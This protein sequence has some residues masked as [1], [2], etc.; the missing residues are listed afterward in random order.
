MRGI[1]H[2]M[3]HFV[4]INSF[5]GGFFVRMLSGLG[6]LPGGTGL[7]ALVELTLPVLSFLL[8]TG[9]VARKEGF[10]CVIWDLSTF[11]SPAVTASPLL[12]CSK[13]ASIA[14]SG[15]LLVA[16]GVF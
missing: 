1:K 3:S 2:T 10:L 7:L 4:P 8:G 9:A 11:F 12:S 15:L 6:F 13:T 14:P 16:G 5:F